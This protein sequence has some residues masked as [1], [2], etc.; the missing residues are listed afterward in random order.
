MYRSTFSRP[1]AGGEW[2]ASR[3]ARFAPGERAP[4]THWIEGWVDL[5]ADMDDLGKRKFLT[6]PGL[7]LPPLGSPARSQSLYRLS[8]PGSQY[9]GLTKI[10]FKGIDV[11]LF[12]TLN[13]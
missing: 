3:P 5:R 13:V 10:N 1:L 11:D 7:E 4:V 12:R 8:Y 6:V 2:S 9:R